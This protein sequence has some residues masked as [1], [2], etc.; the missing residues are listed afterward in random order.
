[1]GRWG[2]EM[3]EKKTEAPNRAFCPTCGRE[4]LV[5]RGFYATH[6]EDPPATAICPR[7][8]TAVPRD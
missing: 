5:E 6:R 8:G 3:D 4:P 2:F 1:M 7:S